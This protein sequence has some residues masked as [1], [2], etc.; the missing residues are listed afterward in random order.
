[1]SYIEGVETD[2]DDVEAGR[3]QRRSD[4][5]RSDAV[6]RHAQCAQTLNR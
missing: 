6:S 4:A 3:L 5:C 1:M 2:V